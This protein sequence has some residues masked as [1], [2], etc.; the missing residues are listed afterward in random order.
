M[1]LS[2]N[3]N[4]GVGTT[5]PQA[6]L[7]VAG[8][9]L[10]TEGLQLKATTT[11]GSV[12]AA[13]DA[14]GNAQW[15]ANLRVAAQ[16]L[17]EPLG[18]PGAFIA[19][20]TASVV[21]G[22]AVNA[23]TGGALGATVSGG[24]FG[25]GSILRTD[26]PNIAGG[27]Y[28]TVPGGLNNQ[29]LG[30]YSL[31]A[32]RNARANHHGSFVWADSQAGNFSS[33]TSN[34][35]LIRAH[36][37]VGINTANPAAT[38]DIQE[39]AAPDGRRASVKVQGNNPILLLGSTDEDELGRAGYIEQVEH[40]SL[41]SENSDSSLQL[42][43][44]D[45]LGRLPVDPLDGGGTS[46]RR[47]FFGYDSTG[48]VG[49]LVNTSPWNDLDQTSIPR[50]RNL[51]DDGQGGAEFGGLRITTDIFRSWVKIE[52]QAGNTILMDWR[53]VFVTTGTKLVLT[54][55]TVTINSSEVTMTGNLRC[56]NIVTKHVIAESYTNGA[57]NIW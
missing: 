12:L 40:R 37:G 24:G 4:V 1:T 50:F 33:G 21:A 27:N 57:G 3:G 20:R 53:G 8:G 19:T 26:Q 56:E 14:Q 41:S 11:P 44:R 36:N 29:A 25:Y 55:P 32:G 9:K 5:S 7:D 39:D 38:L 43:I 18:P 15:N 45:P 47:A 48:K 6:R 42:G 31:A 34:Q 10:A 23:V 2:S 51:L 28:A 46:K 22:A 13:A 30:D 54:A 52:D 49:S 16:Q 35:F 17:N